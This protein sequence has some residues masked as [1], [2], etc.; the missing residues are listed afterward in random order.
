MRVP[1]V[2]ERRRNGAGIFAH[3]ADEIVEFGGGNARH[4]MRHKRVK[5]FGSEAASLAHAFEPCRAVKLDRAGPRLDPVVLGNT[6][7]LS[8]RA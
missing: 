8:H 2:A 3:A 6:D 5:D 4:Y 1:A 7:I